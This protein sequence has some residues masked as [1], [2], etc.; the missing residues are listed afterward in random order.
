[1]LVQISEK[2]QLNYY[3]TICLHSRPHR[4]DGFRNYDVFSVY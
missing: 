1:L 3:F 2:L 4:V